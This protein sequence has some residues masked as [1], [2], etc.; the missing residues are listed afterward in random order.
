MRGA[1]VNVKRLLWAAALVLCCYGN[2]K[3]LT[4]E[5]CVLAGKNPVGIEQMTPARNAGMFYR[6]SNDGLRVERL[7][8]T[9]GNFTTV[10]DTHS[11][12]DCPVT[13][14]DG[15]AMSDNERTIL[16]WTNVESI[17][18]YS[19]SA[20]Y[21]TYDCRT[22]R[23]TP[24]SEE[25]G[26]EIA[27]LSPQGDKVAYVHHNNVM[28]HIVG[29]EGALAVTTDGRPQHV[30]NGVPDWVYQEELSMLSSLRWSPDGATLA[31]MRWDETHVPMYSMTLYQGDCNQ[32]DDYALYPGRFDF[33]YPVAG[34]RNSDVNVHTYEV[35]TGEVRT[36][37]F[38]R[39][40]QGYVSSIDFAP[41][42]Q[43]ML[44]LFNRK[45]NDFAIERV[46]VTTGESRRVYH[47]A[48]KV[49][50]EPDLTQQVAYGE[51]SFVI[52]SEQSGYAQLYEWDYDNHL[53]RAITTG[54]ENVTS[55]YGRD[56]RG[57]H[58]Y[59][60]TAGP[61]NRV[62]CSVDESGRERLLSAPQGW[63]SATFD[64]QRTC[65]VEQV[66]DAL[67]PPRYRVRKASG[68]AVRDLELNEDYA[69]RFTGRDVPRREFFTMQNDGV[70][71]NGYIIKPSGFDPTKKYPVIMTQY[72][73]PGSQ[74]VTNRWSLDWVNYFATQGY[75]IACVDG[76]GTGG[77]SRDFKTMVYRNLGYYETIDQLAA[78]RFMASQ[79][80]V[81]A[82]RI[83]IW[84][85]SY[86]G[87]EVLMAMSQPGSCYAA[88][89]AIAPVTSWRYYD[90][91]YTERFMT[92]PQD[93]EEAYDAGAPLNHI[94]DLKGRLLLMFGSA[95]DNVHI[96]NSM[97]YVARLHA[98]GVMF[99]MM[100]YTNMNHS[101]NG[102]DVRLPLYRR[103]LEHFDRELKR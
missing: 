93:N 82:D 52:P 31:F 83:G 18:R 26:E 79:P 71:L 75:V 24:V 81:D 6:L 55:Y 62:L 56:A 64:A 1:F 53:L 63:H 48:S 46:D 51:K 14:W 19:F 47:E 32:H 99:D 69:A 58:Y 43:L 8:I 5:D 15:F 102:C 98:A 20:D 38:I 13:A 27:T 44:G 33:K 17:Y 89:V 65:Y 9:T 50:I 86:G 101:I 66:S 84:G 12:S 25:G 39:S 11:V 59:Q 7:D 2:G 80:W 41:T 67:T 28:L 91:T 73:G 10:F 49:W 100:V 96:I 37:E 72:S 88:G 29:E 95:D 77:R 23:L 35:A 90:T 34:E 60:R 21:Y 85:W 70:E 97:Q 3:A 94:D 16:L 42:G 87:Y 68:K 4:L 36:V 74:Q 30:I 103:V 76:R 92:Q 54:H 40:A 78:A 22:H 45:Q 61:L 57:V